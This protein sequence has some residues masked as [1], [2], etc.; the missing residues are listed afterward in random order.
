MANKLFL[1]TNILIDYTLERTGELDE[2]E[3]I[4]NLAE[5]GK[6]QLFISESVLATT[7]YFLEKNKSKTLII[8]REVSKVLNYLTFKKDILSYSLEQFNDVEDGLLYFI[9]L[10]AEIH[11]FITRNTKDFQHTSPSMPV[12]TPSQYLKEIYFNDLP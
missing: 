10:K 1:D 7:I 3:E 12:L 6:I 2:I 9:A 11:F 4:F 5:E 8:I